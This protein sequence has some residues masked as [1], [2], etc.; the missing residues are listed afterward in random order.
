MNYLQP[1]LV[2]LIAWIAYCVIHSALATEKI[3]HFFAGKMKVAFRYYRLCYSVFAMISLVVILY[4]QWT[5]TTI[6]LFHFTLARYF[7]GSLL[8]IPGLVIMV[9]CIWKYFYELSGIQALE[10]KNPVIHLQQSGL[11][12]FVRHPL[13]LGTLLSIWGG[14]LF[15]PSL[16]NLIACLVIHLYV[17]IGIQWEER[18]LIIEFGEEYR[19]YAKKVPALIPSF[20]DG[21]KK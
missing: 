16:A 3:K 11:H 13:Y 12:K 4:L 9:I 8:I 5:M 10:V 19:A 2:L 15:F 6:Q 18:K 21:A 14:F 7:L 1:H 20:R 17:L